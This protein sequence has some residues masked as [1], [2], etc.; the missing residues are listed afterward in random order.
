V[1]MCVPVVNGLLYV[2][3]WALFLPSTMA[4]APHEQILLQ[5]VYQGLLPNLVGLLLV[6]VAVRHAGAS[7]TAAFMTAVPGLG[8]LLGIVFLGEVP[9]WL[10][11]ASLVVLTPGIVLAAVW[12]PRA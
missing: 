1:L 11:W 4:Q 8:T 3:L 2:P 12:R 7:L 9:G 10:G 6:S 5:A